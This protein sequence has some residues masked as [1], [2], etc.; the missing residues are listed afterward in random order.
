MLKKFSRKTHDSLKLVTF[1]VMVEIEIK[2]SQEKTFLGQSPGI[3]PNIE[4]LLSSPHG[5]MGSVTFLAVMWDGA[6]GILP[7][8][9]YISLNTQQFLLGLHHTG[10]IDLST[11]LI[12][13]SSTSRGQFVLHDPKP[14][15]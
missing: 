2:I 9:A 12:S 13:I 5:V 11:W 8:G 6:H 10:M 4:L 7:Q 14:L 15:L 3:V 1:I